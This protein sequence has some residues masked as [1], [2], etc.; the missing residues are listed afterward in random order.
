MPTLELTVAQ[1]EI[2]CYMVEDWYAG[3][4]PD[5]ETI[6]KDLECTEEDVDEVY[7]LVTDLLD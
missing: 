1:A 3:V 7:D 2:L 6:K 5:L 4:T